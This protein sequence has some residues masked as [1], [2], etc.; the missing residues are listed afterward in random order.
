VITGPSEGASV[1]STFTVTGSAESGV[2]EVFLNGISQGTTTSSGTWSRQISGVASG[3]T[4]RFT[5]R[6][7]DM[8]GNVSP[9]SAVRTVRVG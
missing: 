1:P 3:S 9:T 8:A 7:Y 2:V 5:A 4:L 6:S